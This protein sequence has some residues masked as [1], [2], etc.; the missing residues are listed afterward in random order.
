VTNVA[1]GFFQE[2]RAER[3]ME[4]LRRLCSPVA[5]VIRQKSSGRQSVS[6]PTSNVTVGDIVELRTGQ[7]VPADLRLF[8]T[9]NLQIDESLLTGESLT[10]LK[11]T[12]IL[13]RDST[14]DVPIG[15]CFNIAYSG[16]IVTKGDGRGIVYAT[17]MNTEI[18]K[19]G[20][21]LEKNH[22]K[23]T[24]ERRSSFRSRLLI[25]TKKV[26]GLYNTSPLQKKY[27]RTR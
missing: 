9:T 6:I 7:V 5:K 21:I 8:S 14:D 18:G 10:A 27:L 1:I 22:T 2:Y 19:I 16:T 3:A 12:E 24:T 17:G 26:L 11:G 4:S 23:R 13:S 25:L 20:R 15:D